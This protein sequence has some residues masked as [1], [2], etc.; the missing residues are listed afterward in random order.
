M[1][2]T[3]VVSLMGLSALGVLPGRSVCADVTAELSQ[4]EGL[5]KIGQYVQA[6]QPYLKVIREADANKPAGSE[7]VATASKG[8]ALV[9]L[10]MD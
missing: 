7:A 4:A 10:A 3:V 1:R 5:Y 9:Y 6:E 8:L 2:K